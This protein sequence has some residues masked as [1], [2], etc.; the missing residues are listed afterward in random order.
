M[1]INSKFAL[2]SLI[3]LTT[4]LLTAHLAHAEEDPQAGLS[5][6][7][8]RITKSGEAK[9]EGTATVAGKT[10]PGLVFG[11]TKIS[12]NYD[13]VDEVKKRL[14]G[15]ATIFVKDGSEFVRVSTNVLKEDGSRAVGTN[16]AHNKAYDAVSKGEKFC[17][18]VEI[19]GSPYKTCY[20]PIKVGGSTVGIFYFGYKK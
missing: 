8:A 17:G 14:G 7:E 3:F 10:V 18:D 20:E 12:N 5:A 2:I 1:K 19:L 13:A 16:L 9:I 6:L 11:H 15:T 4:L